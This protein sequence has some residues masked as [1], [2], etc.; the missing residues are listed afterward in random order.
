MREKI[1]GNKTMIEKK[2]ET[3][4][5]LC[6]IKFH[7]RKEEKEKISFSKIYRN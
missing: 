7:E 3:N 1:R 2:R 4:V 6:Y 5:R